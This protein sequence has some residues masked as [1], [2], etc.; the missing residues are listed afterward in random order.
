MDFSYKRKDHRIHRISPIAKLVWV[1]GV[2]LMAL[3]VSNPLYLGVLLFCS[4]FIAVMSKVTKSWAAYMRFALFLSAILIILNIVLSPHGETVLLDS[5]IELPLF[6]PLRMTAEALIFG[7][8]MSLRIM[9][10]LSVFSLL[11]FTTHPDDLLASLVKLKLPYK[12]VFLTSLA[13]R[14]SQLLHSDAK[15][16]KEAQMSR[17]LELE[18]GSRLKRLRAHIPVF[19]PL[20]SNSLERS[21][22][23]AEA[24]EARAFGRKGRTFFKDCPTTLPQVVLSFVPLLMFIFIALSG[25]GVLQFYPQVGHIS[26]DSAEALTLSLIAGGTLALFLKPDGKDDRC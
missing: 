8:V 5:G 11:N 13:S 10:L 3:F 20:L 26:L 23:V 14:F 9:L 2:A 7:A 24:M 12:S 1:L 6:G 19:I 22:T 21:L 16:I 17:G 25:L 18:K 15:A 4:F